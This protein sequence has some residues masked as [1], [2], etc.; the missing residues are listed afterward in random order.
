MD[1]INDLI[2]LYRNSLSV[3]KSGNII[4]L[5]FIFLIPVRGFAG[6]TWQDKGDYYQ[7]KDL[8]RDWKVFSN[9]ENALVPYIESLNSKSGSIHISLD[10]EKYKGNGFYIKF[11]SK[12]ALFIN[13]QLIYNA[14]EPGQR[15]FS[16][17]SLSDLYGWSNFLVSVYTPKGIKDLSTSI[18]SYSTT[19]RS[20]VNKIEHLSV[21]RRD[22]GPIGDF[23][24]IG[25]IIILILYV[26]LLNIGG[27]VFNDYYNIIYSF[28]RSSSDE[29]V[30]RT[31][32]L[33]RIDLI[34]SIVLSMVLS[35]LIVIAIS[36]FGVSDGTN[37][38]DS[39]GSFF[40]KWLRLFVFVLIWVMI[41]FFIIS[42]SSDLFK[43]REIGTIH[44]FEY[45]RITNFYSLLMFTLLIFTLFVAQ[46]KLNLFGHYILYSM[47]VI[48]VLRALILYLKFLNSSNFTK[49]YLF[50]YLCSAELLPV[51][52]GL[53]FLLRSNLIHPVV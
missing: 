7:L 26:I 46:I 41:R 14:T 47:M 49:L 27:R 21:Y 23:M 13:N 15:V 3:A 29:F 53:K 8:K 30:N 10:P 6:Y 5:L 18:V 50:A 4:L 44:T 25:V 17:D 28:I 34:F 52:V 40:L 36:Q 43:M 33:S 31:R 12:A 22:S 32:K 38:M 2:F 35:F 37:D 24:K 9:E 51:I 19:Y 11:K 48:G 1:T 16:I 39:L 42:L 45:L 20:L